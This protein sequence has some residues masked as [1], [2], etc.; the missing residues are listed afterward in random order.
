[1]LLFSE[2]AVMQEEENMRNGKGNIDNKIKQ[3]KALLQQ[4]LF[5]TLPSS[6][7]SIFGQL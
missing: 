6:A 1:V 5:V 2:N 4:G 3:S 7:S